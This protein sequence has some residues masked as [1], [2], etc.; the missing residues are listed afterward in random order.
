[1]K[2][3]YFHFFHGDPCSGVNK[4][5]RF[6]VD[7]LNNAGISSDIYA[8]AESRTAIPEDRNITT[9]HL[10][11][12]IP[13]RSRIIRI[14]TRE[15]RLHRILSALAGSLPGDCIVYLRNPYPSPFSY[16]AL[17]EHRACKVVVEYQ[18]IEPAEYRKKGMIGYLILDLIFGR[19][20]RRNTDGIVGV[21]RE[22][23]QYELQRSGK[24][25]L[26][27]ITLGNGINVGCV[28]QRC[29]P[30]FPGTE[31]NLL[32]VGHISAW[33]GLDRLLRGMAEYSGPVIVRLYIA[34]DGEGLFLLKKMAH[35]LRMEDRVFFLGFTYGEAL[36]SL[37]NRCHA[38]V[39]SL[40]LHRL[41]LHE[42]SILKLR[43]YCARGIPFVYGCKDPDFPEEFPFSYLIPSDDNA[44]SVTTII[45][46]ISRVYDDHDHS[47]TMKAYAWQHLDWSVKM[48]RLKEFLQHIV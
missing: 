6:Q 17:R 7:A 28:S 39:G 10:I 46:F 22:I 37:F 40:G 38:A 20:L 48:D 32:F 45:E 18:T 27:N 42:A 47:T 29:P 41:G 25:E 8:V 33:H 35:D 24:P 19:A 44:L 26:P 15:K 30:G 5:V 36:D 1:M 12:E 16:L 21:T 14:L 43:E 3:I 9:V 23:T 2:V 34:G 4:K 13:S 31:L 11:G